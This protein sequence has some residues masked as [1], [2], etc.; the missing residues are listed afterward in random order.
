MAFCQ[1][2]MTELCKYIVADTDVP[3]GDI[4]TGARE[5]GYMF[6]QYKKNPEAHMKRR[7]YRGLK[8]CLRRPPARTGSNR[9]RPSYLTKEMLKING[10]V[11]YR[12]GRVTI[13][14]R[15][16]AISGNA[17]IWLNSGKRFPNWRKSSDGQVIPM[18]GY[19]RI[20]R[21]RLT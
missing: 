16:S 14:A 2:F 13:A 18:D 12:T 6:G 10:R 20:Q 8:G 5:I 11:H 3:A 7:A 9:I 4:G 1:S 15:G 21:L 19:A 17:A